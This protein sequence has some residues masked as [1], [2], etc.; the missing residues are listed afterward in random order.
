MSELYA[1][2]FSAVLTSEREAVSKSENLPSACKWCGL[3]PQSRFFKEK[4]SEGV[5]ERLRLSEMDNQTVK[6]ILEKFFQRIRNSRWG[7]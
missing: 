1:D 7:A 3:L 5:R 4:L 6:K 2:Y